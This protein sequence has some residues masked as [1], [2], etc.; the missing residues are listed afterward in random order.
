M[1]TEP[2]VTVS[3]GISYWTSEMPMKFIDTFQHADKALYSAKKM[4]KI[5]FVIHA[6][7]SL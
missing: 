7:L 6:N 4:V 1:V 3:V 5:K 2:R